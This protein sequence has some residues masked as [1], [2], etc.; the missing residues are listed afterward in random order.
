MKSAAA[1]Q[2]GELTAIELDRAVELALASEPTDRV[3]D[4]TDAYARSR[5]LPGIASFMADVMASTDGTPFEKAEFILRAG[6]LIGWGAREIVQ[7]AR[8]HPTA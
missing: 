3:H 4:L 8:E 7:E 1:V 5:L 2:V 6:L